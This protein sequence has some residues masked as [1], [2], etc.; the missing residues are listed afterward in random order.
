MYVVKA[1]QAS[2]GMR[3]EIRMILTCRETQ[4]DGQD[5]VDFVQSFWGEV[6]GREAMEE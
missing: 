1:V 2:H 6:R 4:P 5:S 3:R